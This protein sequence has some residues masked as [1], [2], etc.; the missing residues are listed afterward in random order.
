MHL[1]AISTFLLL[2]LCGPSPAVPHKPPVSGIYSDLTYNVEGGDLLGMELLVLPG[3]GDTPNWRVLFQL[4]DG[5]GPQ[6]AL[7]DL[8]PVA[9]HYE[10]RIS[11]DGS[12]PEMRFSVR[13]TALE[14][15]VRNLAGGADEH[16]RLGRSY[17]EKT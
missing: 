11:A 15:V 2:V 5:G 13:F 4:A 3:P 9:D 12:V 14:A 10:F 17:W 8:L 16:L 6:S 1:R 7:V